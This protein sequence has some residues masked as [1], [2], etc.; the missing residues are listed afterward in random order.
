MKTRQR[1]LGI[2][3]AHDFELDRLAINLD[4]LVDHLDARYIDLYPVLR[5]DLYGAGFFRAQLF[6]G[7]AT[8]RGEVIEETLSIAL[9]PGAASGKR[10]V[11]GKGEYDDRR[12]MFMCGLLGR[13]ADWQ[14]P[15]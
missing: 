6:A 1:A 4:G 15:G 11:H 2:G 12:L 10:A 7:L 5:A 9:H 13:A 8:A 14:R 3:R